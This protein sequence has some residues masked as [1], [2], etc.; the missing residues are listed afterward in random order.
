MIIVVG[1][2]NPGEE[3]TETRHNTGRMVLEAVRKIYG[4]T[5]W[6]EKK[7]FLG[8][9]SEGKIG[10][11]KVTLL[12]PETFMNNSGQSV[13]KVITSVK[14]ADDLV[15]VYDDLDLGIGTFKIS[16]NRSAGG[17]KG[18]ESIIKAIKT[19]AFTRIRVGISPM[20]SGG[21]VKRPAGGDTMLDFIL[22]KFKKP[23]IENIKKVSKTVAESLEVLCGA[24]RE[25][26]MGKFN[27]FF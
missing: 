24:G 9:V 4:M 13:A 27:K 5:D 26:A 8:L 3:Y 16:Y 2:G 19:E 6:E 15:V 17:H 7:P 25:E 12:L 11:E 23:E 18:L 22:A 1:L 20:T 14:K 21:K 10:K